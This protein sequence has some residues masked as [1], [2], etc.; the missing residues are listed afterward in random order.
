MKKTAKP[1]LRTLLSAIICL[2]FSTGVQAVSWSYQVSRPDFKQ[3]GYDIFNDLSEQ[4]STPCQKSLSLRPPVMLNPISETSGYLNALTGEQQVKPFY[5]T[6][7]NNGTLRLDE[8]RLPDNPHV[9]AGSQIIVER[10]GVEYIA[11]PIVVL[12]NETGC[13]TE[14]GIVFTHQGKV[15]HNKLIEKCQNYDPVSY[16][17]DCFKSPVSRRVIGQMPRSCENPDTC[18]GSVLLDQGDAE[19]PR[20]LYTAFDMT[21]F[22]EPQPFYIVPPS[23]HFPPYINQTNL[24]GAGILVSE[25]NSGNQMVLNGNPFGWNVTSVQTIFNFIKYYPEIEGGHTSIASSYSV[26]VG[27]WTQQKI[28]RPESNSYYLTYHY[29]GKICL[30]RLPWPGLNPNKFSFWV[31]PEFSECEIEVT[32]D[33]RDKVVADYVEFS[34]PYWSEARNEYI[35]AGVFLVDLVDTETGRH[36]VYAIDLESGASQKLE[37]RYPELVQLIDEGTDLA[38]HNHNTLYTKQDHYYY[39][40]VFSA[41]D[42]SGLAQNPVQLT[43]KYDRK[44]PDS[45]D[46]LSAG[47]IGGAVFASTVTVA[48]VGL[49]ILCGIKYYLYKRRSRGYGPINYHIN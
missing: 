22:H 49:L 3:A 5:Y 11:Q 14:A 25:R 4:L 47:A 10:Q 30:G 34:R 12:K 17:P 43:L 33:D 2:V 1:Q 37:E 38:L 19:P 26:Y 48:S 42:S 21:A 41:T 29:Q 13:P 23:E 6:L 36:Q 24:F 45:Q 9:P 28:Y 20:H 27:N 8:V 35:W 15:N 40:A 46:G 7:A 44:L 31:Q 16:A 32:D 18:Y 39:L